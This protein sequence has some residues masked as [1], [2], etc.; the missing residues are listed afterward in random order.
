MSGEPRRS[1]WRAL[2]R[3]AGLDQLLVGDLVR[4]GETRVP[5]RSRTCAG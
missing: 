3:R 2:G 5:T 1:G 4:P